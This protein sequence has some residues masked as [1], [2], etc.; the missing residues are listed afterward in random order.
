MEDA[1]QGMLRRRKSIFFGSVF[2]PDYAEPASLGKRYDEPAAG[3][4]RE[5]WR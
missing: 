1:M 3:L 4:S 5:G 2:E